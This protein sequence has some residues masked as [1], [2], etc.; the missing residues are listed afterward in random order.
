MKNYEPSIFD[1]QYVEDMAQRLS[2][3]Y[4]N[5]DTRKGYKLG[6][7]IGVKDAKNARMPHPNDV[8]TTDECYNSF[9]A[10]ILPASS[11]LAQYKWGYKD[12]YKDGYMYYLKYIRDY[13]E[14][15]FKA[16]EEKGDK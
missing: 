7:T 15:Y 2:E 13:F 11:G 14:G 12:G 8:K 4:T 10:G 1:N 3:E 5:D 6:Y 9:W 16:K